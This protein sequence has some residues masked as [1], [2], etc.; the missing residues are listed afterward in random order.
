MAPTGLIVVQWILLT[1]DLIIAEMAR[2]DGTKPESIRFGAK[3]IRI[4]LWYFEE[5]HDPLSA[6]QRYVNFLKTG[7]R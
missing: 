6:A 2:L 5:D 1:Y 4:L 7:A 3:E